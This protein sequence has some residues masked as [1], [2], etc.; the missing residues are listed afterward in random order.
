MNRWQKIAWFNLAVI[1]MCLLFSGMA[2]AVLA[3]VVALPLRAA[4]GGLGFM[5]IIGFT[6]LSPFLFRKA[7]GQ[8]EFDER[9]QHFCMRAWFLGY[10]ASYLFFVIVCMTTWFIH[11]PK[12]TI[13]V[14]VLPLTVL[15]GLM[16]L[17]L[18][19]SLAILGQYGRGGVKEIKNEQG[20]EDSSNKPDSDI[21]RSGW[22][23]SAVGDRTARHCF[24]ASGNANGNC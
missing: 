15:G 7:K 10:C 21:T 6:G 8:V 2:I 19:H 20:T 12:G 13:S 14:N 17:I 11:G 24:L 9:D 1:L 18:V 16:V 5:G 3:F 23:N 4:L 22:S